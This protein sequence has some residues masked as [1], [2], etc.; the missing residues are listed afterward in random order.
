[1][2]SSCSISPATARPRAS[3]G[4]VPSAAADKILITALQ[5]DQP[6]ALTGGTGDG[7]KLDPNAPVTPD[8]TTTVPADT[9]A[10][11]V[12]LPS[13]VSGQTAAQSTCTKG[14]RAG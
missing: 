1:M 13:S 6:I 5:N 10:A 11:A 7:T 2:S 8:P 3:H 9:G 4:V 12:A 14:Q